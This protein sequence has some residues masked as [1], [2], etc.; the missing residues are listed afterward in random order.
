[1][2]NLPEYLQSHGISNYSLKEL[3]Y[4]E[5]ILAWVLLGTKI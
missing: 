1:V 3:K 5:D 2:V 4:K